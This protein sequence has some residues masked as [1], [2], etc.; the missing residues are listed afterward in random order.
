M[1]GI[2]GGRTSC[3]GGCS[4]RARLHQRRRRPPR[5]TCQAARAQSP[6]T[7]SR[8]H[9]SH[10]GAGSR[11]WE[12]GKELGFRWPCSWKGGEECERERWLPAATRLGGRGGAQARAP[13]GRE[14]GKELGDGA[15]LEVRDEVDKRGP[16]GSERTL[17]PG[18][19]R[20]IERE[21]IM[22]REDISHSRLT[23]RQRVMPAWLA[24]CAN[25]V[26][27]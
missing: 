26:K 18:C 21:E 16:S 11:A 5:P 2:D 14:G 23:G 25:V 9:A 7:G 20:G 3:R 10:A 24:T 12:G 1:R 27:L 17:G 6:S 22:G 19:R 4:G 13:G 15:V 8:A